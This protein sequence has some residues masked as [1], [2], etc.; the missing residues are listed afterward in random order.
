MAHKNREPP[1]INHSAVR[2][3]YDNFYYKSVRGSVS[4]PLHLRRLAVRLGPWEGKQ[5]LDVGCGM[6]QWLMAAVERGAIPSGV[7]ISQVAIDACQ[8]LLPQAEIHCGPAEALP[9]EDKRFDFITCLGAL[10]HFLDPEKGLRE[11]VRVAKPTAR[12]LLLVPNVDFLTRRMGLYSGTCQ[13]DIREDVR[14]LDEWKKLFESAGLRV[15]Q[16]WRDLHILSWSWIQ[17]GKWYSWPVR[18]VQALALP[19]WPLSWQYQVYHLCEIR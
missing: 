3:F 18:G 14:S 9:F 15:S 11:M 17:K 13:V 12:F 10:E 4:A 7:D 8:R 19:F 5:L 16:R 1:C 2:R 6:G